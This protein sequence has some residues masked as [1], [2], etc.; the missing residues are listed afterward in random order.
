[1]H[2]DT[3]NS[4]IF[5]YDG[6]EGGVGLTQKAFDLFEEIIKMSYDLVKDCDCES[7]CPACIYSSQQQTDDKYLNKEGTLLILKRLYE[8]ILEKK[9]DD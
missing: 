4:T 3:L 5:I 8:M 1:M 9:N 7:G 6:F 2:E